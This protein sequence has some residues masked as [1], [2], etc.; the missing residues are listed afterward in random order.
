MHILFK[1]GLAFVEPDNVAVVILIIRD[2]RSGDIVA[3]GGVNVLEAVPPGVMVR[4]DADIV[5]GIVIQVEFQGKA[6]GRHFYIVLPDIGV[7]VDK[8]LHGSVDSDFHL[9]YCAH[10]RFS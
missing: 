6:V 8:A 3:H 4:P 1:A 2:F 10:N 5:G 7:K 9:L